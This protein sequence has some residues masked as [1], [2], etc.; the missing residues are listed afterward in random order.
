MILLIKSRPTAAII[1]ILVLEWFKPFFL[2]VLIVLPSFASYTNLHFFYLC[3]WRQIVS[4]ASLGFLGYIF[5]AALAAIFRQTKAQ[6]E[7][8]STLTSSILILQIIAISLETAIQNGGITLIVMSMTFPSP[9]SDMGTLP[10][11][12]FFFFSTGPIMFAIYA[13]YVIVQKISALA[14]FGIVPT[15]E[16]IQE[17]AWII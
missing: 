1:N 5:G 7:I 10:V 15:E 9:Y 17:K 13:A 4:G 11:M 3:T 16:P 6:V 2:C 12:S 14:G 8:V